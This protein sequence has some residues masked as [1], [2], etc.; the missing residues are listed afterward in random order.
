MANQ[1][2][3]LK[4]N[5]KKA[6]IVVKGNFQLTSGKA[7]NF[8]CDFKKVYGNP[9]LFRQVVDALSKKIKG[10]GTCI[11]ATGYGGIP[12]ATAVSLK[13]NLPLT[14]VR[15][16]KRTHGLKKQ[17][18]GYAPTSKDKV[19]IIEDVCTYGTSLMKIISALKTTKS[20]IHGCYVVILRPEMRLPF[21]FRISYLIKAE[22][23]F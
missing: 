22:D 5:L 7:A 1:N 2:M 19:A 15:S 16:E 6:N 13:L 23:L 9:K 18:E 20:K 3:D 21:K 10:E 14:L 17:I 8:Y 4:Y 11:V 12:L